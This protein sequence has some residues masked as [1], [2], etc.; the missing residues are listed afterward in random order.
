VSQRH[1][2]VDVGGTKALGV[3][4][5]ERGALLRESRMATPPDGSAILDVIA[6]LV[7]EIAGGDD[8]TIGIGIAG[9]VERSGVLLAAPN[10]A[11]REPLDMRAGLR[12]RL[13]VDV[14]V[15]NDATCATVAEWQA[16]AAV[17]LDDVVLVTLGT[18]IGGGVVA[19]GALQRGTHGFAGELGHMVVDPHGPPCPCGRRGCWERYASGAGLAMLARQAAEAGRLDEVTRRAGDVDAVRGEHVRAAALDGDLDALAVIDEFARWVALGLVNLTNLLDPAMLVLGGGFAATPG[20]YLP[21]IERWFGELLYSSDVRPAPLLHF[22]H[23]G[24]HAGAIG[25]ALLGRGVVR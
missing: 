14:A 4:V 25:A 15:D 7:I 9:L 17:G 23:L 18:G 21:P 20:L 1:V 3:E 16:G 19:G 24:E 22:A 12:A 5:D 2:G 10:L 8:V 13:G 11:I 6:A